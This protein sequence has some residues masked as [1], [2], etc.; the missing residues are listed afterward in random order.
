MCAL[1]FMCLLFVLVPSLIG[2]V[3]F[4]IL[5]SGGMAIGIAWWMFRTGRLG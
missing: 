2:S 3:S 1:A 5:V 4:L